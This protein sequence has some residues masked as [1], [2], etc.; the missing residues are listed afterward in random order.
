MA[1]MAPTVSSSRARS[2]TYKMNQDIT[3]NA[4]ATG[5]IT[6][7]TYGDGP[8]R[9]TIF[10]FTNVPLTMTD[11]GSNGSGGVKIGS[12]P[13]GVIKTDGGVCS[14]TIAYGSVTDANVIA[15]VGSVVA[16]ADATLT[17]TEANI[18]ASTAAA[19]TSGAGTFAGVASASAWLN[20]SG[21]AA[22]IY[23]NMATSTD[24]STNNSITFSGYLIVT[25]TH[26]GDK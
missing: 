3:V 10:Q 15:S 20:G 22:D 8:L 25:W 11:N 6:R 2:S 7:K 1:T 12:F 26:L 18:I 19:T 21:T 14:I 17:S 5:T 24:P 4:P 13:E 9:Q 23:V 16:A